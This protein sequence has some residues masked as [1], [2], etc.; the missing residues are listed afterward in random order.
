LFIRAGSGFF[1]SDAHPN[2]TR[3]APGTEERTIPHRK[4]A[5]IGRV[6]ANRVKPAVANMS[7]GG[8]AFPLPRE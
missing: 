2:L 1:L 3:C 5:G 7:L 8:G 6:I 4:F